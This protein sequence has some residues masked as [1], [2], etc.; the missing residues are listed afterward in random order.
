MIML[1]GEFKTM[2]RLSY[3]IEKILSKATKRMRT[4]NLPDLEDRYAFDFV[5]EGEL[6]YILRDA[7]AVVD[8]LLE[9]DAQ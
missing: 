8:K 4:R 6:E 7:K 3:R 9:M 5:E 1:D 2:K